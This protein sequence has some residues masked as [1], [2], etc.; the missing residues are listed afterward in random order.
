M[1]RATIIGNAAG[2]KSTISRALVRAHGLPLHSVDNLQ[3]RSGW[4]V[5]PEEDVARE[6]RGI[7]T[8]DRWLLDGWGP[9][10]TIEERFEKSDTIIFIDHSLGIHFWWAAKRQFKAYFIP[11]SIEAPVGCDLVPVTW[12]LF[13]MIWVINRDIR[14][15]LLRLVD[16][17]QG[18]KD[19]FHIRSPK[20]L[21]AF[22]LE[23]CQR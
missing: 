10:P 16:R 23:H 21:R 3:W 6:I 22:E 11:G 8:A 4:T 15:K 1:C 19:V 20:Q 12:K 9:W 18:Q 5:V 14:P 17:F 2:G 13:K 7:I